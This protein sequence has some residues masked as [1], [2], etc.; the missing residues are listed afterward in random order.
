MVTLPLADLSAI[1][2]IKIAP[3]LN[4]QGSEGHDAY[5][6]PTTTQVLSFFR[7]SKSSTA[8]WQNLLV[9]ILSPLTLL[10]ISFASTLCLDVPGMRRSS[11][12]PYCS[13]RTLQWT[14]NGNISEAK[15]ENILHQKQHVVV[16]N[17][18]KHSQSVFLW[19]NKKYTDR[20]H[21]RH[22][23]KTESDSASECSK[24]QKIVCSEEFE[25]C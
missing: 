1:S 8:L 18:G 14:L 16:M 19:L 17:K 6:H 12:Q 23:K 3:N 22:A 20:C 24:H 7:H 15:I 4:Q 9:R 13:T 25:H 2:P 21:L 11:C 5:T 10:I